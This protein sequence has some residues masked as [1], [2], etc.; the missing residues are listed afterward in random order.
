MLGEVFFQSYW[1]KVSISLLLLVITGRRS[2]LTGS[3]ADSVLLKETITHHITVQL[4]CMQYTQY[5]LSCKVK[6][7][8]QSLLHRHSSTW[9][10]KET[11]ISK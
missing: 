8:V 11:K 6:D 10:V 4:I 5:T 9:S 2:L 1:V 3:A 7:P